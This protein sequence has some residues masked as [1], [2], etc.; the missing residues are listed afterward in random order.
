MAGA[1]RKSNETTSKKRFQNCKNRNF[2]GWNI[3]N[4]GNNQQKEEF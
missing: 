2:V 1:F 3:K 4:Q